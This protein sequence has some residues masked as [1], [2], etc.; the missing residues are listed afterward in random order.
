[1]EDH[2]NYLD[3]AVKVRKKRKERKHGWT[4]QQ[5]NEM[6][7]KEGNVHYHQIYI[8]TLLHNGDSNRKYLEKWTLILHHKRRK[9]S[10]KKE[11]RRY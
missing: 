8:Y 2:P 6:I 4:A 9:S 3:V 10:L 11:H 1:V 7:L 5:V